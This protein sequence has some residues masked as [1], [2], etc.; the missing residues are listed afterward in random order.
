MNISN[1]P[2][3]TPMNQVQAPRQ[4]PPPVKTE[5]TEQPNKLEAPKQTA[6]DAVIQTQEDKTELVE[7]LDSSEP[8]D[9][10]VPEADTES[11]GLENEPLE[12]LDSAAED[13]GIE[14]EEP[15]GEG[16]VEEEAELEDLA[17]GGEVEEEDGEGE[18]EGDDEGGAEPD[19]QGK[20]KRRADDDDEEKQD[21]D[22]HP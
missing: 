1:R 17:E 5:K 11:T 19:E 9:T 13:L 20:P 21:D 14:I 10:S 7:Q 15:E 8:L 3:M 12:S 22:L 16:E 4:A 6:G 18:S 2:Q